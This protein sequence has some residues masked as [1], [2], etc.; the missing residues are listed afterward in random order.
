[1]AIAQTKKPQLRLFSFATLEIKRG[2]SS[3]RLRPSSDHPAKHRARMSNPFLPAFVAGLVVA[4]SCLGSVP[5]VSGL[6]V[7][8]FSPLRLG[9]CRF[10]R[11]LIISPLGEPC[12]SI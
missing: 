12:Q 6:S 4:R 10:Q 7:A 8:F 2:T 9:R 11:E 3:T 5:F 1:M